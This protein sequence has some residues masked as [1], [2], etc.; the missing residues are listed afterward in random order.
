[1][2][3]FTIIDDATGETRNITLSIDESSAPHFL[4]IHIQDIR[5]VRKVVSRDETKVPIPST[6]TA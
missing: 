4:L 2:V 3:S 1:M 5:R 6:S